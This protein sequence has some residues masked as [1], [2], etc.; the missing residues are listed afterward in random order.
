MFQIPKKK[1][2]KSS[3]IIVTYNRAELLKKCIDSLSNQTVSPNEIIIVDNNSTDN[4][5]EV[6]ENYKKKLNI[7]YVFESKK[8]IAYARN[9]G[10][11]NS[12]YD[13]VVFI[14]DDCVAEKD[15]LELMI[16]CNILYEDIPVI[17]GDIPPV[18]ANNAYSDVSYYFWKTWIHD[19]TVRHLQTR[20][21]KWLTRYFENC[22][23]DEKPVE[24]LSLSTSNIS[25]KRNVLGEN[26]IFDVRMPPCEDEELNYRLH[27]LGYKKYFVPEIRVKHL[28]RTSLKSFLIQQFNFGRGHFKVRKKWKNIP[29]LLPDNLPNAFLFVIAPFIIPLRLFLNYSLLNSIKYAPIVLLREVF[30][31][32]GVLYEMSYQISKRK[33]APRKTQMLKA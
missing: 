30:F 23:F 1:D 4:T 22:D 16:K 13:L 6:V 26:L 17:G 8:G 10:I 18:L 12:S 32:L 31:R 2:A 33:K 9:S 14:D 5:K 15:W 29:S 19:F 27:S 11:R 25:F 21:I 24:T 3:V 20:R 28:Y 7:K